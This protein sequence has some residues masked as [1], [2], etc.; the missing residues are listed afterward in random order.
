V[1]S[2]P[3]SLTVTN[4]GAETGNT[5][6][7]TD[8]TGTLVA[9]ASGGGVVPRTGSF[10]FRSGAVAATEC[11]QAI[12]IPGDAEADVDAGTVK[13][14]FTAW[15]AGFTDTDTGRLKLVFLDGSA[16]T[17]LITQGANFDGTS[18]WAQRTLATWVPP[19][20][21]TIRI[22]LIGTR[23]TG[24]NLDA[25]WDDIA[26]DLIQPATGTVYTVPGCDLWLKGSDIVEADGVAISQWDD[27]SG[28]GHHVANT[29]T[30]R[31][32]S[33]PA[34]TAGLNGQPTAQADGSNDAFGNV[35]DLKY[36]GLAGMTVFAVVERDPTATGTMDLL[37][38]DASGN[39]GWRL[40]I[41]TDYRPFFLVA[42][43]ASNRA[44]RTGSDINALGMPCILRARY[45]GGTGELSLWVNGINDD[46]AT[47][48]T[49]P[50]FIKND[51]YTFLQVFTSGFSQFF[52]GHGAEFLV[53]NRAL[54]DVECDTI[55]EELLDTYALYQFEEVE[56]SGDINAHQGIAYD[57]TYN[58][59]VDNT[60]ITKRDAAW[61]SVTSNSSPFSG[62][63]GTLTHLG[64]PSYY[65]GSLYV[66]A[67]DAA[68][69]DNR[70]L[71]FDAGTLARTA[72]HDI[73]AA[74]SG[75][76]GLAI[77]TLRG[78]I[79]I[80][81]YQEADDDVLWYFDLSDFSFDGTLTLDTPIPDGQGITYN[82]VDDSLWVAEGGST[83]AQDGMLY[84]VDPATGA[85]RRVYHRQIE[86]GGEA[87]GVDFTQGSFRWV[88][89]HGTTESVHVFEIAQ[90]ADPP[91]PSSGLA[92]FRI[93]GFIG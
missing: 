32:T 29:L 52:K 77:D 45:N 87:E 23:T 57:G 41:D 75:T 4:P 81:G 47:D 44:I 33:R 92:V 39:R 64:D 28:Q 20:T 1:P 56:V 71:V 24:T 36:A 69:T 74:T 91:P 22:T 86:I 9:I 8:V 18:T 12:S 55:E 66:P 16:A 42:T 13:A 48:G 70:I 62:L 60:V 17:L 11:Y 26:L 27:A 83:V 2:Y 21:R 90:I 79:W 85:V 93:S 30:A 10:F 88:I 7:W 68:G 78:R 59:L 80:V 51:G 40:G 50:A 31:P 3:Y 38:R 89:D 19:L 35:D 34:G 73:S 54:S 5:T 72:A 46:G 82:A 49:V 76:A 67:T 25:Y 15:H 43:D 37:G 63:S 53:F 65:N 58:Y 14:Q 61:S 84:R 6:G